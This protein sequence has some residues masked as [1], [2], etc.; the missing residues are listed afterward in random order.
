M[1]FSRPGEVHQQKARSKGKGLGISF[2]MLEE[3]EC[4]E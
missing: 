1:E 3:G 4:E 2:Q